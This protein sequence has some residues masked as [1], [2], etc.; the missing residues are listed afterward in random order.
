MFFLVRMHDYSCHVQMNLSQ[1]YQAGSGNEK[2]HFVALFILNHLIGVFP[3]TLRDLFPRPG[4]PG[5]INITSD[6]LAL[7]SLVS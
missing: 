5:I 2:V 1:D 7:L 6:T 3:P 4:F